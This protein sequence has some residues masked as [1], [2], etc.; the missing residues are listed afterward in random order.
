MFLRPE[1]KCSDKALLVVVSQGLTQPPLPTPA[2]G[3]LSPRGVAAAGCYQEGGRQQ[4]PEFI[5]TELWLQGLAPEP[6]CSVAASIQA[7]KGDLAAECLRFQNQQCRETHSPAEW[8]QAS[9]QG[10]PPNSFSP[11][12]LLS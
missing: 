5:P 11:R 4:S 7:M 9:S 6:C 1:G 10:L 3:G 8:D 12:P 2:P